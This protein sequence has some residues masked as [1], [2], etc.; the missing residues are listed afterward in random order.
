[1]LD[2]VREN[3]RVL[4]SSLVEVLSLSGMLTMVLEDVGLSLSESELILDDVDVGRADA[5]LLSLSSIRIQS[6]AAGQRS[7]ES[8]SRRASREKKAQC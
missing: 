4:D 8:S 3:P 5:E 6:A 1:M 7:G 2:D